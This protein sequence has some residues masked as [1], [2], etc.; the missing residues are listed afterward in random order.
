MINQENNLHVIGNYFRR[1]QGNAES[2]P[3]LG[4]IVAFYEIDDEKFVFLYHS[5]VMK[6]SEQDFIDNF[7]Y[8]PDGEEELNRLLQQ[9]VSEAAQTKSR[10]TEI[11]REFERA[12]RSF[13]INQLDGN[14]EPETRL[15]EAENRQEPRETDVREQ[16][17]NPGLNSFF[18]ITYTENDEVNSPTAESADSAE[19]AET[20]EGTALMP[21]EN[22]SRAGFMHE[23]AS[24][25]ATKRNLLGDL[26]GE[27]SAKT[28]L[29]SGI[30]NQKSMLFN[31]LFEVVEITEKI[32]RVLQTVSLYLGTGEE[33]LQLRHGK[34]AGPG[35][36]LHLRQ[37]ALYADLE[38]QI[39][40]GEDGIDFRN[41][42]DFD[43]WLLASP[44]HID[45]VL[46]EEK[47]IVALK[48][49]P[50]KRDY[51][52]AYLN[53]EYNN[54]NRLTYFLIRNGENVFRVA[55]QW[56]VGQK[57]FPSRREFDEFFM[58]DEFDHQTNSR[59]RV[60]IKPGTQAFERAM[61]KYEKTNFYYRNT[62]T[63]LQGIIDRTGIFP[64]LQERG[65]NLLYMQENLD[66]IQYIYDAD[67]NYL[68]R[69]GLPTFREW[70]KETNAKLTLGK[71][72]IG[73]FGYQFEQMERTSVKGINP[74]SRDIYVI[75]KQEGNELTIRYDRGEIWGYKD[76]DYTRWESKRRVSATVYPHDDFI[77]AYDLATEELLDHFLHD[78]L[79]RPHYLKMIPLIKNLRELKRLEEAE[80]EPFLQMLVGVL[81]RREEY[82]NHSETE[83]RRAARELINFYKFKNKI[84]RTITKDAEKALRIIRREIEQQNDRRINKTDE[85]EER[86]RQTLVMPETIA[87]YRTSRR[88]VRLSR[89]GPDFIEMR[90][91]YFDLA[92]GEFVR[93]QEAET[94]ILSRPLEAKYMLYK[95]P[96]FDNWVSGKDLPVFIRRD[97][98]DKV[99]EN[100]RALGEKHL[101]SHANRRNYNFYASPL[102]VRFS[103]Y[104]GTALKSLSIN[105]R[106][107]GQ[108]A[109]A[110][111][112]LES[113]GS[114]GD[115]EIKRE[116]AVIKARIERKAQDRDD[117]DQLFKD[118]FFFSRIDEENILSPDYN[119]DFAPKIA[120]YL[121]NLSDPEQ[122]ADF[123]MPKDSKH[124]CWIELAPENHDAIRKQVE[125]SDKH[126]RRIRELFRTTH[127]P[128]EKIAGE[129]TELYIEKARAEYLASFG[130]PRNW[131]AYYAKNKKEIK[132]SDLSDYSY[133]A[134][135]IAVLL[136][137]GK[138]QTAEL[139]ALGLGGIRNL[140]KARVAPET[141]LKVG[142]KFISDSKLEVFTADEIAALENILNPREPETETEP[143]EKKMAD[144]SG[145]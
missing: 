118:G 34:F 116:I 123:W 46:P 72:L 69:S 57:L 9:T 8:A 77:L 125:E 48:P 88:F 28:A 39:F 33:I 107:W 112:Y 132:S 124:R 145:N 5:R 95:H 102:V 111:F 83:L 78:R 47:G 63:L 120:N 134:H 7:E 140:V 52:N 121:D 93:R 36:K 38:S 98:R 92:E 82:E 17:E 45:Q 115:R 117:L 2:V 19:K 64:D 74:P 89:T 49:T 42:D 43:N 105:E 68:L 56:H 80:E 136:L 51:G 104:L 96:D 27:I 14:S 55:P 99:I 114:A 58:T 65:I 85:L 133:L 61:E 62:L 106:V 81:M 103:A 1:T 86:A 110:Y 41:L 109:E 75:E 127:E 59:V 76:G 126:N 101:A 144:S 70:Q 16:T 35:V 138:L 15:L 87:L 113:E 10:I 130:D 129:I 143:E 24:N 4:A 73:T 94:M 6:M 100:V 108:V 122:I 22:Q 139:S 40:V 26:H 91:E 135:Y 137:E 50:V 37:L 23:F 25:I 60:P 31:K 84:H 131:D 67:E 20:S 79:S 30:N 12:E 3:P 44:A 66:N 53:D 18:D 21:A 71:R 141:N 32:E 90:R 54:Q 11:N 142:E 119:Q 128:F 97:E 13:E 29:I